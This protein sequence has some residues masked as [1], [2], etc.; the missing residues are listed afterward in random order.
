MKVNG[1]NVAN[2]IFAAESYKENDLKETG[3]I[4]LHIRMSRPVTGSGSNIVC[5]QFS[6]PTKSKYTYVKVAPLTKRCLRPRV[7]RDLENVQYPK[8]P[9]T[10]SLS[11][12]VCAVQPPPIQAQERWLWMPRSKSSQSTYRTFS[13]R[14]KGEARCLIGE[15]DYKYES[16]ATVTGDGYTLEYDCR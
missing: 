13:D 5:L 14:K 1:K 12:D 10:G 7:H 11:R 2:T 8:C 4:G 6:C 15:Q 9:T 3:K 16:T